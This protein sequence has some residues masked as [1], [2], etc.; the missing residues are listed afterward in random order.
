MTPRPDRGNDNWRTRRRRDRKSYHSLKGHHWAV[1]YRG[2][3]TST[4]D[5]SSPAAK[6]NAA[7]C[8]TRPRGERLQTLEGHAAAIAGVALSPNGTA[9][10]AAGR[11]RQDWDEQ[12]R[13]ILALRPRRGSH[14]PWRFRRM[15]VRCLPAVATAARSSGRRST[16]QVHAA[17]SGDSGRP[18]RRSAPRNRGNPQDRRNPFSELTGGCVCPSAEKRR[19]PMSFANRPCESR[20]SVTPNAPIDGREAG[21]TGPTTR[22]RRSGRS[23]KRLPVGSRVPAPARRPM[24][25]TSTPAG[26]AP[27]A[28]GAESVIARV[29]ANRERLGRALV[30]AV[31]T[32]SPRFPRRTKRRR[33]LAVRS[34]QLMHRCRTPLSPHECRQP[35]GRRSASC[36][37]PVMHRRTRTP[38]LAAQA[39]PLALVARTPTPNRRHVPVALL[40]GLMYSSTLRRPLAALPGDDADQL[41]IGVPI[42]LSTVKTNRRKRNGVADDVP[43]SALERPLPIR[44]DFGPVDRP[45]ERP[46]IR[47][48]AT[49][50]RYRTEVGPRLT[51]RGHDPLLPRTSPSPAP[52]RS[53]AE[54]VAAD[55]RATPQAAAPA[56]PTV[57]SYPTT[58]FA[59]F[60]FG[61]LTGDGFRQSRRRP[62]AATQYHRTTRRFRRRLSLRSAVESRFIRRHD[63][64]T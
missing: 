14:P 57:I 56:S 36:R 8:R 38:S 40:A 4:D 25:A 29:A 23:G 21:W 18:A 34:D 35:D 3:S 22:R 43:N 45:D 6:N 9:L 64:S 50:S 10:A 42:Q 47:K 63:A 33:M 31:S 28:N 58:P 46:A 54:V 39:L 59:S 49:D 5:S 17:A 12:R 48:P 15:V 26:Y 52:Q 20:C 37:S 19:I 7:I 51:R 53:S 1:R 11:C 60:D 27:G 62:G 30:K 16:G 2:L 32:S 41:A 24:E 55:R 13:R 44:L 61:L